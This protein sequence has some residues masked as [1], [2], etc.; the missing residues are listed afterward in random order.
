M[1]RQLNKG[2]LLALL[3]ALG[4][5]SM[6]IFAKMI[7]VEHVTIPTILA[8][9]FTIAAG[10]LWFYLYLTG[11][12]LRVEK[13]DLPL[14]LVLG[15]LG[16][17]SMSTCYFSSLQYISASMV[18]ILLY[19]YPSFV[20][21]LASFILKEAINRQKVLALLL[22]MLG[23]VIMLWPTKGIQ[24][25]LWGVALGLAAGI[26]YSIYIVLG[27]KISQRTEPKVF[28]AYIITGAAVSF[29]LYGL[30]T[31][32]IV[33]SLSPF[34][35]IAISLIAIFST[36][37]AIVTF[38]GSVNLIGASKA[39]IVSTLEPLFTTILAIIFLGEHLTLLQGVG[40]ILILSSVVLL[41]KKKDAI[42]KLR[43]E[44]AIA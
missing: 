3:S 21:V 5:S 42:P 30:V 31:Q 33:F 41:Q 13:R 20:T 2:V 10:L 23:M 14:I 1:I 32:E 18:A 16:Y 37:V 22:S 44:N 40:G 6:A 7:Y 4:F 39:S 8:F 35:W 17:G 15:A 34:G 29:F 38:F 12:S 24:L 9:R 26:I 19:T 43:E 36:V 11:V 27:G 25:N 28:S